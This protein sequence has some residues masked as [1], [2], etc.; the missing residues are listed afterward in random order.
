MNRQHVKKKI[1]EAISSLANYDLSAWK[2]VGPG[3]QLALIEEVG[4]LSPEDRHRD[5][6]AIIAVCGSVLEPEIH[7]SVWRADSV[8]LQ[9]GGVPATPQIVE[10]RDK[11]LSI[12]FDLFKAAKSDDER[13]SLITTIRRATYSGGRVETT[14]DIL[15]LTLVNSNR[16]AGFFLNEAGPLSYEIMATLEHDYLWDYHRARKISG[17]KRTACHGAATELMRT[18]ETLRDKFNS[19]EG[20]VRFKVLVGFESVF[21]QQWSSGD[22]DEADDSSA[23]D[24]YRSGE[25][26]KYAASINAKNEQDW[27]AVIKQIASI[28]SNDLAT[29]PPFANFLTL[30]GRLNPQFAAQVLADPSGQIDRFSTAVLAGLQES[31]DAKTYEAEI[32]RALMMPNRLAPL[33]FHLRHRKLIDASLARRT[34]GRALELKNT[35]A[36]VECLYMAMEAPNAVP[37]KSEFFEP[38]L[39]YLNGIKEFRWLYF[40]WALPGGKAFFESLSKE[41]AALFIPALIHIPRIEHQAERLMIYLAK[42]HPQLMWDCFAVRIETEKNESSE[43]FNKQYDAVPY[44]FHGLEKELSKDAKA[45]VEFGRKLFAEDDKLF[46][47]H[48]GR[49]L[50]LAFPKCPPNFADELV[51][52]AAEGTE[53]DAK[54]ILAVLENYHGEETTHEILKRLL[55]RFPKDERVRTGVVISLES[56]GVVM[57]EFGFANALRDK[58]E[59]VRKWATD[60]RPEVR[61]FAEDEMRS[62]ELRITD[63]QRHAEG[64][65]ALRELE[66]D[67]NNEQAKSTPNEES[68]KE[69]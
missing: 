10:I 50:A 68:A 38:A 69:G 18:I 43:P 55:V 39:K 22:E 58:L 3:V 65:K 36:V 24:K 17:S 26:E 54:F 51:T 44:Q 8:T 48:G 42:Q 16:I 1:L 45:A 13:R 64:R 19:D 15:K 35:P 33:V 23:L 14:D 7:G 41:E 5:R 37:S 29:F 40:A 52:L 63:E 9:A 57:G 28:E 59:M 32:E 47:F 53:A 31:S 11:A 30:V 27:L 56:T 4:K 60:S 21:P 6:D 66:F 46:R 20:F 34:L 2:Q 49:L 62:L 12:L 61:A 67:S 25:A